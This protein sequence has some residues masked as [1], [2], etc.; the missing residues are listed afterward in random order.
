MKKELACAFI[1]LGRLGFL[2]STWL[3][4]A[5]YL[6][7]RTSLCQ[8]EP[9]FSIFQFFNICV[10][11]KLIASDHQYRLAW[12]V[13]LLSRW[14]WLG[15]RQE[16]RSW[17]KTVNPVSPVLT[18]ESI[19]EQETFVFEL[20]FIVLSASVPKPANNTLVAQNML[21]TEKR[22]H[23]ETIP[24]DSVNRFRL[25]ASLKNPTLESNELCQLKS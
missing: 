15:R 14:A 5:F 11:R 2:K 7:P 8:R 12:F 22:D 18:S 20:Y 6:K 19:Y 21:P 9:F 16:L 25:K 13:P 3:R 10:S 1:R 23:Y 24:V 4:A 17:G